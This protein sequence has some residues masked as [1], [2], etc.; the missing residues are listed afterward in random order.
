MPRTAVG[1]RGQGMRTG[2]RE[3]ALQRLRTIAFT[4]PVP[5]QQPLHARAGTQ[6]TQ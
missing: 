6:R 4:D 2:I 1:K 3:L 5:V